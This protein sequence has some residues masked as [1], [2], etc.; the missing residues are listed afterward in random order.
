MQKKTLIL[1]VALLQGFMLNVMAQGKNH[2]F[3]I[4]R[5]LETFSAIYK[6]LD[7]MYVDSLDAS[8]VIGTGIKAMLRSLDPYTEYYPQ[9]EVKNLKTMFTG[10]YAGVGSTIRKNF[11]T[12]NVVF[13]QPYEGMPAAEVGVRKGDEIVSIDDS[14]MLG[15]DVSYVSN[16]LR[17][18][19]GTTF[20]LRINRPT[21]V[22]DDASGTVK[23]VMKPM[24]MKV[25]RRAIQLPPV[26]YFGMLGSSNIGYINLDSFT[27][28]CA[29]GVKR[30][31]IEL[32]HKG[33]QGLVFD[34][35]GN[36]GGSLAEAVKIVNMF[37]PKGITLVRTKGK[38]QRANRD[39]VTEAEPIDTVMPIIV[40]VDG[41]T[42]SASEITAGSLQ[43]LDR[44]VILGTRTYGKGLVQ[45]P[46]DLPHNGSMKLTTAKYYIP[47]G[48]CIQA[49][50]YKHSGGGYREHIP[51]SLT[52]VFYTLGGREVRDGGGIKPDVEVKA[53]S[54]P[55]IAFYLSARDSSEVMQ[56]W[57][58]RYIDSHE[59]IAPATEFRISDEDWL[60]FRESVINSEFK[61]DQET[62]KYFE[63]LIKIAKF[64]GYYDEAKGEFEALKAKLNHDLAHDLDLNQKIIRQL[65]QAEI[66]GAYYFQGGAI[67]SQNAYDKVLL[68]AQRILG[69]KEEYGSKLVAVNQVDTNRT[70]K[71]SDKKTTK[72]EK[73]SKKK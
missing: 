32:R 54:I 51:D 6:N 52:K 59:R 35:R 68:E 1:M 67:A 65:V 42:A 47:S 57:V 55:N 21:W 33:M 22:A 27:E 72:T 62:S 49:I 38:I 12:N 69:S 11:K 16:H 37:V 9:E 50:N 4:Q 58:V 13:D 30:A 63:D 2:N 18:D 5:N 19:A 53:D 36:G 26:P 7:M 24:E 29:T 64:E 46:M 31:F 14:T 23:R 56:E 8:E 10:K 3:D 60:S 43:D 71:K 28:D 73:K 15:K 20:L 70:D 40:L 66:V 44:A 48:R 45:V 41:N 39:Y 61:Y 34:L 25:T 17:G